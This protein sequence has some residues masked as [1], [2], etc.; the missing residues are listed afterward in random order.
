[1]FA[2]QEPLE[3]EKWNGAGNDFIILDNRK[4]ELTT[5]AAFLARKLCER[6]RSLGADGLI[7]VEN[8]IRGHF[9]VR[10]F[11]PDG[12]EFNMCMNGSRCVARYAFI[13]VIAPRRMSIETPVGLLH[14]EVRGR[15][16][17]LRFIR[18]Y[19]IELDRTLQVGDRTIPFHRVT[20]GDPH[21]VIPVRG[22]KSLDVNRIG[23]RIR[24]HP[25]LGPDGANVNF[26]QF[27]DDPMVIR[28]YERGVESET[29]ACGSGCV[30]TALVLAHKG[31]RRPEYRFKTSSGAILTV[32][33]IWE[34]RELIGIE[35]EG[36]A[37]RVAVGKLTPDAWEWPAAEDEVRSDQEV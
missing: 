23:R 3:F 33:L 15:D 9:R 22:V 17:C 13:N 24:F 37:H 35:L 1:M 20:V 34:E 11:N 36:D 6:H 14:A 12:S 19:T 25:D 28:T 26:V 30:S 7:L 29:L 10:F 16:V 21:I 2:R 31:R 18:S 8:G 32:R 27:R 4:G 5:A